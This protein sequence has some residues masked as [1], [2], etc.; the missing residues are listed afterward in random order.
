MEQLAILGGKPARSKPWPVWPIF[1]E[2]ERAQ[3][4][5]VLRG[6]NGMERPWGGLLPCPKAAEL[7]RRFATY[8]GCQ[9]GI[10]IA[11]GAAALEVALYAIGLKLGDE[12]I[13][14]PLS[15]VASATCVLRAGGVPVFV[16]VEDQTY[17]LD[18]RLIEKAIT[19]RT[20]AILPVHLGGYPAQIEAIMDIADKYGLDV[21]EDCAQAHGSL[22]N[23]KPL[24]CFGTASCFS[25]QT[26]KLMS[27][28]EGGIILTNNEEI[29]QRCHS[30][31]DCGRV[32]GENGYIPFKE[33][34]EE[35]EWGFGLNYRLTEFQA[36][37][38]LAQFDRMETH[39]AH[40]MAN[41]YLLWEAFHDIEGIDPLEIQNGQNIYRFIIKYSSKAFQGLPLDKFL[42]AVQAEGVPLMHFPLR[43]FPEEALFKGYLQY[44]AGS[45]GFVSNPKVYSA[46]DLPIS[47]YAYKEQLCFL[48]QNI[49]MGTPSDMEDIVEAIHK[50]Q[51]LAGRMVDH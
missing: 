8:H 46:E 43:P 14:T 33:A 21:I 11:S 35:G 2:E 37:I 9:F 32:R 15:W 12:V 41:A 1:G 3:L 30:Y 16:D 10:S 23:Q 50:V 26:T 51:N 17:A 40:R 29:W 44:E 24:G 34:F 22:Y 18:P 5:E 38:L 7:E 28:G 42:S 31:K 6:T 48:A 36:A 49:L 27:S 25:F 13:C 20:K 4:D 19:P 45:P 39:K 47:N